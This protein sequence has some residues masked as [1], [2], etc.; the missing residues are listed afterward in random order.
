M[1]YARWLHISDLHIFDKD[2]DWTSFKRYLEQVIERDII[3]PDFV[4]ITGDYRNIS[5]NES[6]N[7]TEKYIRDLMEL[8]NLELTKNL[9]LVPGNHDMR[10]QAKDKPSYTGAR[11]ALSSL[12][13]V[14]V[15]ADI[16]TNEL[17][18]LLPDGLEP[19]SA[20]NR[21]KDYW[22]C[23]HKENPDNYLDRLCGVQRNAVDDKNIVNV[24]CLLDGFS[25]YNAMAERLISW[26]REGG[27]RP[28]DAHCRVWEYNREMRL[29]IVHLNT[30]LTSDGNRCHYQAL[31][32][33]EVQKVFNG[34]KN[35]LPT[36]VL[37][38]NS[39]YDLH[40]KI[41]KYLLTAM[42]NTNTCA[43]LCGDSHRSSTKDGIRLS[44]N[45]NPIPIYVCGKTAADNRDTYSENGFYY[46]QWDGK[47][48]EVKYYKWGLTDDNMRRAIECRGFSAKIQEP[49]IPQQN[50]LYIGYLSCN[51]Y[52]GYRDKYHLGHAYFIHK[53]DQLL[54]KNS[55][56]IIF[57][58]SYVLGNNRTRE[59]IESNKKYVSEMIRMW[60]DCFDGEVEVID[61]KEYIE[62]GTLIESH[63][64][65]LF[66]Y[67]S[68]M[69]L[70]LDRDNKIGD[71]ID[72][73][74]RTDTIGDSDYSYIINK[75]QVDHQN[76]YKKEEI[77]S[78][79]YLLYKRPVWYNNTWLVSFIFF[80]NMGMYSCVKKDLGINVNPNRIL[81]T[82]AT[83][84]NYVWNAISYCA[85]RYAYI[86]FPE[87]E[88]FENLMDMNCSQPMKSSNI[89][90]AFFLK[91]YAEKRVCSSEF[92][93]HVHQMFGTNDSPVEIA[94][95]Y[96]KRLGLDK[97]VI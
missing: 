56:V 61:I 58:S 7:V 92:E 77:L 1:D 35:N 85:K 50:Y 45:A 52:V 65:K 4:V 71:I 60:R 10:P 84:N 82:E 48:V 87:V 70:Q 22:L 94:E 74:H 89:E 20:Y 53:I 34:I 21:K 38:H 78:F 13:N 9:F 8:L 36:L 17:K 12:F 81:I 47:E 6:F 75:L 16:R 51:P 37:A 64:R 62:E 93:R 29:N 27:T 14:T 86:N 28:A 44:K 2:P 95:R 67:V 55:R 23:M 33:N 76:S 88:Y 41:C 11:K 66:K 80:W 54:K 57:T 97:H 31:D 91:D 59:S 18:K 49:V 3:K 32:L 43:W 68:E 30:A 15:D 63:S 83:R 79:A 39:F 46:Y 5:K 96:Y 72:K 26:Y 24:Q 73:W 25:D 19:W 40:P 42:R 90:S 69:E